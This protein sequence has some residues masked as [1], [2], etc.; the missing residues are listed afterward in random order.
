MSVRFEDELA[1]SGRLVYTTVGTSMLPML[2]AKR[3]LI[4]VE[5]LCGQL[6]KY[7]VALYRD[8][9]GK[10][11][12]HRVVA[13]GPDG[14]VFRGD[15]NRACER[16]IRE[17]QIV[18]VLSAFVRDGREIAVTN[19]CYRLYARLWCGLYRPRMAVR[20]CRALPARAA[21]KWRRIREHGQGKHKE[22]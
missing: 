3:D 6:K 13:A 5:P 20:W 7:D 11:I 9:G 12:L 2:R 16:G 14:Y 10:Y 4:V 15:H 17:E 19:R 8:A 22:L 1:R 21:R 18:G